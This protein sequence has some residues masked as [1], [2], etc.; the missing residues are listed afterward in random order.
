MNKIMKNPW[1]LLG[2]PALLY[3]VGIVGHLWKPTFPLMMVLTPWFLGI[4]GVWVVLP[5]VIEGKGRFLLWFGI[6]FVGTF[7]LEAIGVA[8]GKIFGSYHYG[9]VLGFGFFGVPLV[10]G[11]TWTLVV[12]GFLQAI[13]VL[14]WQRLRPFLGI[15]FTALGAVVFD[16]IMEPLAMGLGY[17]YWAGNVIPLQNYIA[18]GVIAG[19][20]A[21]LYYLLGVQVK[22]RILTGYL[23]IQMLFFVALR[24]GGLG[25]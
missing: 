24:L 25:V 6:S 13:E 11:F 7:A 20:S 12:L 4:T 5:S 21:M 17:W 15:V 1:F 3:A 14:P 19:G 2:I 8:T 16:W 22:N 9:E 10:I 18:W 23:L